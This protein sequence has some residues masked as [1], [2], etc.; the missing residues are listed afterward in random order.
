VTGVLPNEQIEPVKVRLKENQLL[1]E[2]KVVTTSLLSNMA[3]PL[4]DKVNLYSV[5]FE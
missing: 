5:L 4:M 2:E 1:V 3:T